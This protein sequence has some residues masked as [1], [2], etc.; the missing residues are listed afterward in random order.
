MLGV[1]TDII[2]ELVVHIVVCKCIQVVATNA[3]IST[4]LEGTSPAWV[5][6][7]LRWR[8]RIGGILVVKP[9]ILK[10]TDG[11]LRVKFLDLL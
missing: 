10:F 6:K 5:V 8:V 11:V 2:G 4:M 1:V 9:S 3:A 7:T